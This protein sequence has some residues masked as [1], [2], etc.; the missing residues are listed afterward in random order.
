MIYL[1][2]KFGHGNVGN[3][4]HKQ[5]DI[6]TLQIEDNFSCHRK[7]ASSFNKGKISETVF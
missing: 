6:G 1:K 4:S 2:A 7:R 5:F 3:P